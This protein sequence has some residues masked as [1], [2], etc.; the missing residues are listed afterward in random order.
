MSASTA[1]LFGEAEQTAEIGSKTKASWTGVLSINLPA[2]GI[3]SVDYHLRLG[4]APRHDS[5][6]PG[7]TMKVFILTA[8]GTIDNEMVDKTNMALTRLM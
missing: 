3:G 1:S 2:L 6:N 5:N 8:T 7:K 4:R